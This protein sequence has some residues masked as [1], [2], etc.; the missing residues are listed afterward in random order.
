MVLVR[1]QEI[2][3]A[4]NREVTNMWQCRECFEW[5]VPTLPKPLIHD[6][7]NARGRHHVGA[8]TPRKHS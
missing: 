6:C 8:Y 1:V 4:T 7:H 2:R 5:Y 3:Q